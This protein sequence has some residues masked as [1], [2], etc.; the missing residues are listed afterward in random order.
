MIKIQIPKEI[1]EGVI[2]KYP[3]KLYEYYQCNNRGRYIAITESDNIIGGIWIE[4]QHILG[5]DETSWKDIIV[6]AEPIIFLHN[7][8]VEIRKNGYF[9]I[10]DIPCIH[11]KY[12][13]KDTI[14]KFFNKLK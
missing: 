9:Y 12:E 5:Y 6:S 7:N 1:F 13:N 10:N 2:I 3:F 8:K 11:F 14:N 4:L